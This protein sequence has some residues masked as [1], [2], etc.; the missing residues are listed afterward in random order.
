MAVA[1]AEGEAAAARTSRMSHSP[2][3]PQLRC[4]QSRSG[5]AAEG[6]EEEGAVVAAAGERSCHSC[7]RSLCA[8]PQE[9]LEFLVSL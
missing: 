3:E 5:A 7:S 6:A 4:H 8:G 2:Q 9:F 1:G